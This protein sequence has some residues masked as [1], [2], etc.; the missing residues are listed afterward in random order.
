MAPARREYNASFPLASGAFRS[1]DTNQQTR[2]VEAPPD[3]NDTAWTGIAGLPLE[4]IKGYMLAPYRQGHP[5]LSDEF[6]GVFKHAGKAESVLDFGCGIGRN[7]PALKARCQRLYGYD[8]PAMIEACRKHCRETG[9]VLTDE[10]S[11]VASRRYDLTV[12]SFTFQHVRSREAL[13]YYIA[14]LS[15]VSDYLYVNGRHWGDD[16]D[17]GNILGTILD[18]GCFELVHCA[19]AS[20]RILEAPAERNLHFNAL[21]R[22]AHA[23]HRRPENEA[24]FEHAGPLRLSFEAYDLLFDRRALED[25]RGIGRV[26]RQLLR[27]LRKLAAPGRRSPGGHLPEVSFFGSVHWCPEELP[28]SSVVLIHDVIPLRYPELFEDAAEEW[29]TSLADIARQAACIVTVSQASAGDIETCLDVPRSR[30]RLVPNGVSRLPVAR[31]CGIRLP[32]APYLAYLGP[33]DPH[34]NVE[35]LL[36]LISSPGMETYSLALVGRLDSLRAR[37]GRLGLAERVV[38]YDRLSDEEAGFVL[39]HSYALL[40]PSLR[41]GFG[42]PPFEAALLGVPVVCSDRP[43]MNE[44]LEGVA[45]LA[46]PGDIRAWAQ[47]VTRLRQPDYRARRVAAMQRKAREYSPGASATA[48]VDLFRQVAEATPVPA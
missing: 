45:D 4:S 48:L 11:D 7:F 15:R 13:R 24:R 12:A 29:R 6:D 23:A 46:D 35:L 14:S 47:A 26:N 20:R 40:F 22:N 25:R 2:P 38:F 17:C 21:L 19:P 3:L 8:I 31:D 43:A 32:P 44:L 9:V 42:L 30:I 34:K 27:E 33:D 37:A 5:F 39:S 10:W 18:G 36:E 41:E 28:S 1:L 16:E